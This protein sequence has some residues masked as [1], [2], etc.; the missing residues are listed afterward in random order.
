ME[1]AAACDCFFVD[2]GAVWT[3]LAR[4]QNSERDD[5]W[6]Y[7]Q[8]QSVRQYTFGGYHACSL[9]VDRLPAIVAH[10]VDLEHC[11]IHKAGHLRERP[12]EVGKERRVVQSP[13]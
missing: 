5:C 3:K 8:I 2:A 12:F 1:M 11:R 6:C 7:I 4:C 13:F 10:I 9:E